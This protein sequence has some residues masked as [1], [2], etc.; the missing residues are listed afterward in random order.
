MRAA[1]IIHHFALYIN[2][3]LTLDEVDRCHSIYLLWEQSEQDRDAIERLIRFLP[4]QINIYMNWLIH[5]WSK[6]KQ[7]YPNH[8]PRPSLACLNMQR[9]IHPGEFSASPPV[10]SP[11]QHP[12]A[13]PH[14]FVSPSV[15][16]CFQQV[17]PQQW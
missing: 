16:P 2:G 14:A 11:F 10:E 8:L 4:N 1:R 7:P 3:M 6:I 13:H 17:V 9:G 15:L 12:S 5:R